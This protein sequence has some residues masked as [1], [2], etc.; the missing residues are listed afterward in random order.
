MGCSLSYLLFDLQYISR[1]SREVLIHPRRVVNS[2]TK[3][4]ESGADTAPVEPE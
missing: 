4:E 2:N 3:S 1:M